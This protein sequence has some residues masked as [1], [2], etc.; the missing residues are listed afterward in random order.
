MRAIELEELPKEIPIANRSPAPLTWSLILDE[1]ETMES[2]VIAGEEEGEGNQDE[3]AVNQVQALGKKKFLA[4]WL[5]EGGPV[6]GA[7]R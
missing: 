1:G 5:A 3:S 6:A 2:S 4:N 7:Y